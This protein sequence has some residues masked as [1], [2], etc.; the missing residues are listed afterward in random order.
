[1]LLDIKCLDG[2]IT[3]D[4]SKDPVVFFETLYNFIDDFKKT[5]SPT[6]IFPLDD[7]TLGFLKADLELLFL[8]ATQSILINDFSLMKAVKTSLYE[9]LG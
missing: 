7:P 5:L 9:Y 4:T 3:F 8:K 1:M 6:L 2:F